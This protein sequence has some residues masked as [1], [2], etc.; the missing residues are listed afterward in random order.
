M[1][2][3]LK[4]TI[5]HS[6]LSRIYSKRVNIKLKEAVFS[7]TFD[8]VPLSGAK[9]GSRILE[10][11]GARGTYYISSKLN[12]SNPPNPERLYNI[13]EKTM[14]ATDEDI[15]DLHEKGHEIACHSYSHMLQ[16]RMKC[17]DVVDDCLR[18]KRAIKEL[19]G[20]EPRNYCYPYGDINIKSK[21]FLG[22]EYQTMRTVISGINSRNTDLSM[23][24]AVS[25]SSCSL[26][27]SEIKK[28]VL[29]NIKTK[30]WLI[31]FTHDICEIPSPWGTTLDDF[32]WCVRLVALSGCKIMTIN[33]AISEI[34]RK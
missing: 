33:N 20:S 26:E 8:D 15:K 14:F 19:L 29:E 10:N 31:F 12:K 18:N 25:L 30:G 24:K 11:Y 7:F 21:K 2:N 4:S 23:L 17:Q 27:K 34:N 5:K 13:G 6:I 1:S 22:Y 28:L 32:N 3:Q 9:N 16:S